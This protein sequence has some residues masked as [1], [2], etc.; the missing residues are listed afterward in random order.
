MQTFVI[1]ACM[2]GILLPKL[3][4]SIWR[5]GIKLSSTN[6]TK[7]L[8][9][10][11]SDSQ[12]AIHEI[13]SIQNID[14]GTSNQNSKLCKFQSTLPPSELL[15]KDE[16]QE[17]RMLW[18]WTIWS[19]N[20]GKVRKRL[21]L[22]I[23]NIWT[24][25]EPWAWQYFEAV[26]QRLWTITDT[27]LHRNQTAYQMLYLDEIKVGNKVTIR[28][29]VSPSFRY[30]SKTGIGFYSISLVFVIKTMV[31][32]EA[33]HIQDCQEFHRVKSIWLAICSYF[34]FFLLL[35]I[36]ILTLLLI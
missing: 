32:Q 17:R 34:F 36:F 26:N 23:Q 14:G 8:D 27:I 6:W 5:K 10:T 29:G 22:E 21:T 3:S 13:T 30:V 16:Y 9:K 11:G 7:P 33:H 4:T 25:Y 24:T 12:K 2:N 31:F 20:P 18:K 15:N 35:L 28:R 19:D 1:R